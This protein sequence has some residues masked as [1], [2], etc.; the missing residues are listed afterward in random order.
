MRCPACGAANPDDARWCGQCFATFSPPASEVEGIVETAGGANGD[1]GTLAASGFQHRDG[2]VEWRCPTCDEFNAIDLLSC[3]VCGTPLSAR[4]AEPEAERTP[5]DWTTALVLTLFL[6]G[7]GHVAVGHYGS[8]VA[9]LLLFATWAVGA[10]LLGTS[11]PGPAAVLAVAPL[12][13]GVVVVWIGSVIDVQQ[14][15]HGDRELLGGR[16]LLWL[17]VGV[18]ALSM[19]GLVAA[20]GTMRPLR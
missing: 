2:R 6:P 7:A 16:A 8:G 4:Y 15:R 18:I 1:P 11:A 5:R 20:A 9:R 19:V 14:L 12:A 10:L 17:V 13:L 3:A